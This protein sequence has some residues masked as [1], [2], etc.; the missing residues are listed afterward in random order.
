MNFTRV[1]KM[2]RCHDLPSGDRPRRL[3]GLPAAVSA[4]TRNLE[5]YVGSASPH[6]VGEFGCTVCHEGMGQ[7]I[8]FEYASHTPRQPPSRCSNGKRRTIGRSRICGTIPMLPTD[9]TEASCAPNVTRR[10]CLHF[11]KV[12]RSVEAYG[13][14]ERAGCYACHNDERASTGL[15]KPG[16]ESHED[17]R[18]A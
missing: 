16:T 6:P 10:S 4:P 1:A 3:R 9:M 15:R 7:S 13:V 14:Y 17:R 8:T 5:A 2:D 12:R 11:L 18:Q